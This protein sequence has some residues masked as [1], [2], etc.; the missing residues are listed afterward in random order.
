MKSLIKYF[1]QMMVESMILAEEMEILASETIVTES[2]K[3]SILQKL[4]QKIYDA[5][6]TNN[7]R[8]V[9]S[10]KNQHE[11]D[12]QDGHAFSDSWY[13]PKVVSFASV[14]GPITTTEKYTGLVKKTRGV[15]WSEITDDDFK[16]YALDDKE[17]VK[18]IKKTYGKAEKSVIII[19]DKDKNPLNLIKA[20]NDDPKQDGMFY[21]KLDTTQISKYGNS[22]YR[23]IVPG[24]I[25]EFTKQYY[26]YQYRALKA[27]EVIALLNEYSNLSG[28]KAY[29]LE[30]TDSMTQEYQRT[31]IDRKEAQ[32]GV[33]N[34]DKESLEKLA[35]AQ[36]ARY[37]ALVKKMKEEKFSSNQDQLLKYIEDAQKKVVDL[38]KEAIKPENLE[39]SS[40]MSIVGD[41]MRNISYSYQ[42]LLEYYQ[43]SHRSKK[44][45][46]RAKQRAAEKGEEFDEEDYK[47][48]D[49]D[50]E[51]ATEE[52]NN[53][54]EYIKDIDKE[55]ERIRKVWENE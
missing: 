34:Y 1:D 29:A 20:F 7:Q 40:S 55:I 36:R 17:L 4:A 11:R 47:K 46:E 48:Y 50:S 35:K 23:R 38:I 14:L 32:K 24:G 26:S 44:H 8:E 51:K 37:E 33:I 39:K 10:K 31:V 15:K 19:T 16:E 21:F 52:I 45:I 42:S 2:F 22:E 18:L 49:F 6:K 41:L 53:V 5:E 28:I 12:K 9:Q 27:N 3:S 13:K 25:K 54:V 30:I 43:S